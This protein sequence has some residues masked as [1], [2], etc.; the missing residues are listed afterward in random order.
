MVHTDPQT[1]HG[2]SEDVNSKAH[3]CGLFKV[4]FFTLL[5][6]VSHL[7]VHERDVSRACASYDFT[8][9]LSLFL[10]HL[11]ISYVLR[12]TM[13]SVPLSVIRAIPMKYAR[14]MDTHTR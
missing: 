6:Y 10:L 7:A 5:S 11:E 13:E 3:S 9:R 12:A 14:P 1:G 2:N 4:V 8:K